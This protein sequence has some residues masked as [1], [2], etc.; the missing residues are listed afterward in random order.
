MT[1]TRRAAFRLALAAPGTLT[2]NRRSAPC[3]VLDISAT[4]AKVRL[5]PPT[6]IPDRVTLTTRVAGKTVSVAARIGRSEQEG[7]VAL[8]FES[9]PRQLVRLLHEAQRL[10]I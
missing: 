5:T 7:I 2:F 8:A 9:E 6:L 4:G 1:E 10:T 3:V